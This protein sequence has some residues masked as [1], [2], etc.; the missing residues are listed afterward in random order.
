MKL[1][2]DV[3]FEGVKPVAVVRPKRSAKMPVVVVIDTNFQHARRKTI[4]D[5]HV[6]SQQ[7]ALPK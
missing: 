3:D 4:E 7:S 5:R 1:V 2:G 6:D